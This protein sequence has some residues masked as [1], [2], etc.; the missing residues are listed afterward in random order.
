MTTY[1]GGPPRPS[2]LLR[3]RDV[4][5]H[6]LVLQTLFD[7]LACVGIVVTPYYIV[8]ES[9]ATL[10]E[11][12]EEPRMVEV[13]WRF[14]NESDVPA[15]AAMPD[16]GLTEKE[17]LGRLAQGM[18]AFGAWVEG[19]LVAFTW[20]NPHKLDFDP[21]R[22]AL[23][24]DEAYL[25]G[26]RTMRSFRGQNLGPAMRREFYAGLA[27]RGLTRLVS[28]IYACNTPAVRFKRKLHA[29]FRGL[30]LHVRLGRLWRHTWTLW[31]Q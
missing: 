1:D 17:D 7:V 13:H 16:G 12:I 31:E 3:L 20:A 29:Q 27:E 14:L 30:Y 2:V 28:V 21:A 15:M 24:P 8:E 4:W 23:Q 26:A 11:Q 22:R 10:P 9:V 5:R 19:R 6:G 18:L 25:F